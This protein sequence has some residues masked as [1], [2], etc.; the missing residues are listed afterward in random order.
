[1]KMTRAEYY[2]TDY[3]DQDLSKHEEDWRLIRCKKEA[4]IAIAIELPQGGAQ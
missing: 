3:T 4:Y 2:S 1:M